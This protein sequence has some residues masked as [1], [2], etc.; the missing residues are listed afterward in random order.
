MGPENSVSLYIVAVYSLN[1][2]EEDNLST[3]DKA[4]EFII[5]L[6]S[7]TFS[8]FGGFTVY[9]LLCNT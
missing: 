6:L 8:L 4:C 9:I 7:P 1:L 5:N 2:R 3:R